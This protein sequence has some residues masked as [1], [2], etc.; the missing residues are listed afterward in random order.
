MTLLRPTN[1][2]LLLNAF[3]KSING[4][5]PIINTAKHARVHRTCPF[6][7]GFLW[8]CSSLE[9]QATNRIK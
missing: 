8:F 2:H 9:I 3:Q 5:S 6:G 4:Q 1:K 7:Y